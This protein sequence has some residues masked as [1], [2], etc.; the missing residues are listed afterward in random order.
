MSIDGYVV[1]LKV[2]VNY[3]VSQANFACNI[4]ALV[5]LCIKFIVLTLTGKF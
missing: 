5:G 3:K 4:T 2:D 1:N